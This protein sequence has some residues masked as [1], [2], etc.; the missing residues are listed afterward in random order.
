M[1]ATEKAYLAGLIDGEGAIM[2]VGPWPLQLLVSI[3]QDARRVEMLE[4]VKQRFDMFKDMAPQGHTD[5]R[6][7]GARGVEAKKV[8]LKLLPFLTVKKPQAR[9]GV[10]FQILKSE[11]VKVYR[12]TK[13]EDRQDDRYDLLIS[14]IRDMMKQM[15]QRG[16]VYTPV[17][18]TERE[19]L[20]SLCRWKANDIKMRQSTLIGL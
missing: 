8:L 5:M 15:N 11:R 3:S 1:K 18:E 2:I 6:T 12:T 20:I 17:A 19:N 7:I 13:N 9:L 14:S 16:A 4:W 10:A